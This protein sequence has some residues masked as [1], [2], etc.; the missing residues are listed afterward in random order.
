MTAPP[1][2]ATFW[3]LSDPVRVDIVDRLA[4]GAQMTATALAAKL[5]MTRQAVARHLATLEQAG[6]VTKTR[7]GRETRFR[8]ETAPLVSAADWL[9]SRAASWDDALQR[10]SDHLDRSAEVHDA[11]RR[12]AFP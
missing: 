7:S 9:E 5:P 11:R 3:A 4:A 1:T 2:S 12:T 10:L 8:V 6:L